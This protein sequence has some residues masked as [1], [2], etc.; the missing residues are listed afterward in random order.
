MLHN[1]IFHRILGMVVGAIEFLRIQDNINIDSYNFLIPQYIQ[2][3]YLN[4]DLKI[5]LSHALSVCYN[6]ISEYR[7][8][9]FSFSRSVCVL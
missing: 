7:S 5:S 3:L 2:I 4:T 9:N 1:T 8:E 6:Y